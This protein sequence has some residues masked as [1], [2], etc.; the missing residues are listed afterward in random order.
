MC[1]HSL[2]KASDL[3]KQR[4]TWSD[5]ELFLIKH[6]LILREQI[7][8]FNNEFS[9]VEVQLDFSKIKDAAFGL[10]NNKSKLF[11]MNYDNAFVDFLLTGTLQAQE[12][13]I[14]SKSEIDTNLKRSFENYIDSNSEE[15]FGSIKQLV[16]KLQISVQMNSGQEKKAELKEQPFAR[17]EKLQD[18]ISENYKHI[19]KRLPLLHSA[20][21]LYL[22]N[23]DVEQIILKRIKNS[24]QQTYVDLNQIV[25]NSYNEEDQIIIACPTSEQIS[26][27]MTV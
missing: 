7:V 5:G 13:L 16:I 11:Q 19:R 9:S 24:I 2:V 25:K 17:P 3:I 12:N 21:S 15:L 20:M 6:L 27:W 8:P 22:C 10:M 4:R 1:V 23:K 18:I 26:L 14:D